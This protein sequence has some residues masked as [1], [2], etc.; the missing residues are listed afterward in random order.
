ML[1]H[2]ILQ[3]FGNAFL[4]IFNGRQLLTEIFGQNSRYFIVTNTIGFDI[5]FN[6]YSATTAFLLLP[7]SSPMGGLSVI[8]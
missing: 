1:A 2:D 6:E 7:S 4:Q 5:S 8:L 3:I